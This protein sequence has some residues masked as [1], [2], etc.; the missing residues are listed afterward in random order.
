VYEQALQERRTENQELQR[1]IDQLTEKLT[2][3]QNTGHT[4]VVTYEPEDQGAMSRAE[5][6]EVELRRRIEQDKAKSEEYEQA[7]RNKETEIQRLER[8]IDQLARR[9]RT[10]KNRHAEPVESEYEYNF[11]EIE[12]ELEAPESRAD[13]AEAELK[14]HLQLLQRHPEINNEASRLKHML[15]E[16]ENALYSATSE[17]RLLKGRKDSTDLRHLKPV[18][19]G[20]S[21]E[22]NQELEDAR[23][24]INELKEE[25]CALKADVEAKKK[26]LG[27]DMP[28]SCADQEPPRKRLKRNSSAINEEDQA[29]YDGSMMLNGPDNIVVTPRRA[30]TQQRSS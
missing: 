17:P 21:S 14:Q 18:A 20:F 29:Q 5:K 11:N 16:A 3:A 13:K 6:A 1:K 7:L 23:L 9:H 25:N 19:A 22:P 15:D 28:K 4:E 30:R 8:K 24:Q 12:R 27:I 10:A 2:I 26:E